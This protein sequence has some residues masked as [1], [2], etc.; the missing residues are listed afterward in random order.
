MAK[1]S[2]S[3][4]MLFSPTA[5][6]C[7]KRASPP[8]REPA[9]RSQREPEPRYRIRPPLCCFRATTTVSPARSPTPAPAIEIRPAAFDIL[10]A[11]AKLTSGLNSSRFGSGLGP[12]TSGHNPTKFPSI[13]LSRCNLSHFRSRFPQSRLPPATVA[14][15]SRVV[16]FGT[17]RAVTPPTRIQINGRTSTGSSP[18]AHH[19]Q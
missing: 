10:G 2:A 6:N 15:Q 19:R 3:R 8:R 1:N 5:R 12:F 7:L 13:Q 17:Q 4:C 18:A 11:Q 14:C 9:A 16:P